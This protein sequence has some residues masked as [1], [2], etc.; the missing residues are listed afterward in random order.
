MELLFLVILAMA[1]PT[2]FLLVIRHMDKLEPE[3]IGLVIKV[4]VMGGLAVVPAGIAEMLLL[5]IPVF[6][7]GGIIGAGL[8]SF[9]VIAPIEEAVKLAVVM[10][11]AWRNKNFNEENDGIVYVGTA[12]IGF[13]MLENVMYVLQNGLT[14]GIMRGITSIPLHVF[15]GVLMGY[16]VGMAKFAPDPKHLRSKILT[17]LLIAV[18]IH[19]AYDTFVL[20]ETEA[21]VL[22]IPMIIALFVFGT[23]YLKKGKA[24]SEKRWG[25]APPLLDGEAAPATEAPP[26]SAPSARPVPVAAAVAD[27]TGS[28]L[29]KI[30]ISRILFGFC[31][32]LWFLLIIGI[33]NSSEK[34]A[35]VIAGGIILTFIPVAIGVMLEVSHRNQKKRMRTAPAA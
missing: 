19:A 23:I 30:V 27:S 35:E 13:A 28:G 33:I 29:Y 20:S 11:V 18:A 26:A 15:T 2:A 12:A 4:L 17:G 7:Q 24:L 10:I 34:I 6:K 1:P 8:Q 3:P 14:V 9:V 25:T 16:F 22:I 31:A 5:S 21:A 32:F